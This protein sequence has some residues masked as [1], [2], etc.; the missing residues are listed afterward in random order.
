MVI[1]AEG[2]SFDASNL[3][4][5]MT[6]PCN[7]STSSVSA[8]LTARDS[9]DG[10]ALGRPPAVTNTTATTDRCGRSRVLTA[11]VFDPNADAGP[12]RWKVDGALMAPGTSNMIV[13]GTHSLEAVV[14]DN[15]GAT[16]TAKKVIS[17][18]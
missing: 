16:T 7:A 4:V 17:C 8:L 15:R 14:R 13:T 2:V 9:G 6:V 3:M 10:S 12:V 5:S 11:A 18:F 1:S